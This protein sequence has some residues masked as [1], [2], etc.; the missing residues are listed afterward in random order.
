VEAML[1]VQL[2]ERDRDGNG[3]LLSI[4]ATAALSGRRR[5]TPKLVLSRTPVKAVRGRM[6]RRPA[7]GALDG[8]T[9]TMEPS[10]RQIDGTAP[11]VKMAEE[12]GSAAL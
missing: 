7:G 2:I 3:W 12:K 9:R 6:A 1:A 10:P 8:S 4:L 5:A 11:V